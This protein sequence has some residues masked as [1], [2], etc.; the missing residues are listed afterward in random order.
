MS[1]N[2]FNSTETLTAPQGLH[3]LCSRV[4]P[5]AHDRLAS[6]TCAL[7]SGVTATLARTPRGPGSRASRIDAIRESRE[8][9]PWKKLGGHVTSLNYSHGSLCFCCPFFSPI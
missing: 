2:T 5:R 1:N 9:K 7:R 6:C 8:R 3:F 4:P